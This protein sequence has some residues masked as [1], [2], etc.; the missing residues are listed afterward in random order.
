MTSNMVEGNKTGNHLDEASLLA[1]ALSNTSIHD[2]KQHEA[3]LDNMLDN[4]MD[5]GTEERGYH[6]NTLKVS[7]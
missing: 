3:L 6:H 4:L 7:K 5:S 2:D 1:S